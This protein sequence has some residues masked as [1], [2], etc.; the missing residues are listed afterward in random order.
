MIRIGGGMLY[1][2]NSLFVFQRFFQILV[3]VGFPLF[4]LQ[5]QANERIQPRKLLLQQGYRQVQFPT[6]ALQSA[7]LR[8][9]QKDPSPPASLS[10]PVSFEDASHSMGNNMLQ[11]QSYGDLPY[12]HGGCD[13][14]TAKGAEVRSPVAGRLEAGHYSY[15]TNPD[16]SMTKFFK[17]WPEQG[18]DLYFEVAVI[19]EAGFR[20]EFH[21]IDR[22]SL[23]TEIIQML[24]VGGGK[25]SVGQTL[26]YVAEWPVAGVGGKYYHHTHYNIV[27]PTG[28]RYN[29]EYFSKT[30]A[31]QKAPRIFGVFAVDQ[32]GLGTPL[33]NGGRAP[34]PMPSEFVVA[35]TDQRELNV[36][37][38]APPFLK[39]SFAPSLPSGIHYRRIETQWDFRS[40][41][42]DAKGNF[43]QL[44]DVFKKSLVLPTGI[45]LKTEGNYKANFFLFRLKVPP[46][47]FGPFEIQVQDAAGNSSFFRMN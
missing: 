17:S 5:A 16:G 35:T 32:N 10:W 47:G 36:Y 13:L 6:Q 1:L 20:Y 9:A 2:R 37:T 44:W 40:R 39:L 26:G 22:E 12:F 31:D 7:K 33:E 19:T 42:L 18:E 34:L 45:E 25:I 28:V 43:P 3:L 15:D 8:L 27:G 29:P 11:F 30:L 14:R 46:G 41:L 24:T 23:P 38:Q 4:L 21:H